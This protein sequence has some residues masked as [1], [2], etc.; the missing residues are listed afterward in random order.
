MKRTFIVYYSVLL[1]LVFFAIEQPV[2]AD[3][4]PPPPPGGERGAGGN[5]VPGGGAPIGDG[6][7]LLGQMAVGYGIMR[8]VYQRRKEAEA[9]K[10][11]TF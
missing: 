3:G 1:F 8:L 9:K 2:F 4:P 7:L 5:Q 6:I 10:K 11:A